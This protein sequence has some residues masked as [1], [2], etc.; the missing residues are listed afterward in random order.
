M[1]HVR[2]N[3]AVNPS[4]GSGGFSNHRLL[5]AAGLPWSLGV[6]EAFPEALI[7]SMLCSLYRISP[8]QVEKLRAF[9][10]AV[11]ELVGLLAAPPKSGFLS[12]LFGKSAQR[13]PPSARKFQAIGGADTFELSQ[14][15]HILH[16]LFSRANAEA[17]WPS[18][19]VL[20]GG[21][22]IGPDL[23]FG[24]VRLLVPARAHAVASFLEVQSLGLLE[25]AYVSSEIEAAEIYW[26]PSDDESE[27]QQE[28][29]ELWGT[30]K[31]LHAFFEQ[32]VRA[33]RGILIC[34]S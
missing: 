14:A 20:S 27:R 3:Q 22:E 25:A 8:E 4:G 32:S 34:I 1:P 5:A 2:S 18:G 13:S 11:G 24:P 30:V 23:G 16:F 28:V 26:Q 17:P 9:P 33:G 10:D 6:T 21:E 7:V 31:E 29:E 19:F 12:R 15:W